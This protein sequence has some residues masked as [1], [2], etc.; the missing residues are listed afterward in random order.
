MGAMSPTLALGD[1]FLAMSASTDSSMNKLTFND[2]D[3][4]PTATFDLL[5]SAVEVCR[6]SEIDYKVGQVLST[7]LF[8]SE[9]EHRLQP[10]IRHGVLGIEMETAAIYSI[11]ARFG[12]KAL[13]ILSVSDNIIT[14][15]SASAESREKQYQQMFKIALEVLK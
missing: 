14:G 2:G 13:S 5:A 11:A 4:A 12:M 10:W 9:D 8:Y 15:V 7:D 3:F 6:S 1:I